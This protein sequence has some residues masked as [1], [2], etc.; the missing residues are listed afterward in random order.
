MAVGVIAVCSGF[1][2]FY[3]FSNSILGIIG[4]I[5]L[6]LYLSFCGPEA[7]V[8][9]SL[10]LCIHAVILACVPQIIVSFFLVLIFKLRKLFICRC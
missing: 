7:A 5:L 3:T 6:P 8:R 1:C 4:T 2:T 10:L 9:F